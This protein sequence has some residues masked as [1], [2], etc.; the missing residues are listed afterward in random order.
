MWRLMLLV[1]HPNND[2]EEDRNDR[3]PRLL[4]VRLTPGITR[5]PATLKI[6]ESR[7]VGGRVHAVVRL[8]YVNRATRSDYLDAGS[9]GRTIVF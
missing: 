8:R 1:K 9:T 7:R 3:Q 6:L 2:A 5:R 4:S